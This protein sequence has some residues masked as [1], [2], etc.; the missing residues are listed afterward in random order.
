MT[1]E[2]H[3]N[4][5]T[6]GSLTDPSGKTIGGEIAEITDTGGGTIAGIVEAG[7]AIAQRSDNSTEVRNLDG[8]SADDVYLNELNNWLIN[9]TPNS[10]QLHIPAHTADGDRLTITGQVDLGDT[11]NS[12]AEVDCYIYNNANK[13]VAQITTTINDGTSAFRMVGDIDGGSV[14]NG[15]VVGISSGRARDFHCYASSD[16]SNNDCPL[17][18]LRAQAQA[19][20][21]IRN[22]N[23]YTGTGIV[24]DDMSNSRFMFH[25]L[26]R[27]STA[28]GI[29]FRSSTKFNLGESFNQ[30][31]DNIIMPG[32]MM[33]GGFRT[34]LDDDLDTSDPANEPD[35]RNVRT[36]VSG[37][38]ENCNGDAMFK[39]TGNSRLII[40]PQ[41]TIGVTDPDS[42]NDGDGVQFDGFL[43]VIMPCR[44]SNIAGDAVSTN[45]T[46]SNGDAL[47]VSK[48]M[49]LTSIGGDAINI[50][51]SDVNAHI[52][53]P[54]ESLAYKDSN[55]F[56]YPA[57]SW[58]N[59]CYHDGWRREAEGSASLSANGTATLA[60]G[61]NADHDINVR[62]KGVSS[63]GGDARYRKLYG[64]DN[65]GGTQSVFLEETNG[66]SVTVDYVVE[67]A[68]KG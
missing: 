34:V 66:S 49:Y 44:M 37:Y 10:G 25:L 33:R 52:R 19:E 54:R 6:T 45:G 58:G 26:P 11:S 18:E 40:T 39:A 5:T 68:I 21:Y 23:N 15:D 48:D 30:P 38:Y 14:S 20:V 59:M 22:H 35:G 67:T 43:G 47:Y 32:S 62:I 57:A 16:F 46:L 56:N 64:Y 53:V 12:D 60:T 50:D 2:K 63:A 27:N 29:E 17:V 24:L 36:L 8:N 4:L 51:P 42:G 28:T 31:S 13:D 3:T 7:N 41:T 55:S 61:I 65:T 9:G 1:N